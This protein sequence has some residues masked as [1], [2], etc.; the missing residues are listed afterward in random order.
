MH[1]IMESD[2]KLTYND[3][4]EVANILGGNYFG[5]SEELQWINYDGD[6]SIS[7]ILEAADFIRSKIDVETPIEQSH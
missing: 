4:E 2:I 3:I 1:K 6:I 7:N 5:I